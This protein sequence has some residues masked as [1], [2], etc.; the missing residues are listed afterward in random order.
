MADAI[1]QRLSRDETL[2]LVFPDDPHI[3]GWG[4]NLPYAVSL[5]QRLGVSEPLPR[6]TFNFPV[7]SMFWAR[8][9]AL[10]PLFELGLSWDDY[11]EEPVPYDGSLLHAIER[12]LP[13]VAESAGFRS[14]VTHV[15]GVTR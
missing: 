11:P 4:K 6:N 2:G 1:I 7:G 15:S 9:A 3:L 8:T 10:R 13:F 5:A 12:I 14:A